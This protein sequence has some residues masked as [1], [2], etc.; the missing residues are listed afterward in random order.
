MCN[1]IIHLIEKDNPDKIIEC[2]GPEE[3]TFKQIMKKKIT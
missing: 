3:L 2:I 1:L